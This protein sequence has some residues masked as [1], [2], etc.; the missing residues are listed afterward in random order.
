MPLTTQSKFNYLYSIYTILEMEKKNI[1][2]TVY[3][4]VL[5]LQMLEYSLERLTNPFNT[6]AT[7]RSVANIIVDS[8]SQLHS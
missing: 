6:V 4:V 1:S 7:L 8:N 2:I 3:R 5:S